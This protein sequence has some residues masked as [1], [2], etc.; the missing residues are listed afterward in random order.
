MFLPTLGLA[1]NAFSFS[2]DSDR[3]FPRIR[4]LWL[5]DGYPNFDSIRGIEIAALA[6][7]QSTREIHTRI[8][9]Q[10]K[11]AGAHFNPRHSLPVLGRNTIRGDRTAR[12][13]QHDHANVRIAHL[14]RDVTCEALDRVPRR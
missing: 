2:L 1:A 14:V 13:D 8:G 3:F 5:F 6:G 11:P 4:F 9:C 10:N 7:Y 12:G